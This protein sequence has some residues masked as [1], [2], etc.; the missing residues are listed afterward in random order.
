[1]LGTNG[2]VHSVNVIFSNLWCGKFQNKI[3]VSVTNMMALQVTLKQVSPY[4]IIFDD[5]RLSN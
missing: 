3:A 4:P 1:M 5:T 2:S